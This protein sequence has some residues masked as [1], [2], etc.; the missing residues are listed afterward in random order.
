M[1]KGTGIPM[2]KDREKGNSMNFDELST[3]KIVGN[4]VLMLHTI[5]AD[6]NTVCDNLNWRVKTFDSFRKKVMNVA[7]D[8][9]GGIDKETIIINDPVIMDIV[10]KKD[11]EQDPNPKVLVNFSAIIPTNIGRKELN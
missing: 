5:A 9:T 6:E 8:Y 11:E 4:K 10:E 7:E 3:V 1:K 2:P